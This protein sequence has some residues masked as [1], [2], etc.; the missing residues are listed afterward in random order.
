MA[1]DE[2]WVIENIGGV[3][4]VLVDMNIIPSRSHNFLNMES[5]H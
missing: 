4:E 1:K 5:V 2:I 3:D